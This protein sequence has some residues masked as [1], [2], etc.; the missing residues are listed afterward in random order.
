MAKVVDARGLSCPHPVIMTKKALQEN[1]EITVIVD[2][3]VSKDN[4]KRMGESLGCE[5][6]IEEK[7][8][9]IYLFIKKVARSGPGA[10]EEAS[11]KGV[12]VVIPSLSMGR[13][14]ADLGFIL[15]R[16]FV[17]TLIE[18]ADSLEKL[19]LFN[20]GV[21]L[22]VDDSPVLEELKGLEER[23]VEILV[24]GTCLD[25]FG[26][27]ERVSVGTVSNMYSITEAMLSAEK[28]VTI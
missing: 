12:V 5:V 10:E 7:N 25:F 20:E 24:C 23:G 17:G 11:S 18:F 28:L 3:P 19:I 21:K 27:K 15:V 14:D 4:V 6:S 9:G 2:N 1:D 16:S 26:L 22:A 8:D 13:G